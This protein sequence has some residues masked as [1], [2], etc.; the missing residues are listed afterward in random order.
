MEAKKKRRKRK[1][2]A[3]TGSP[4]PT[5]DA[6]EDLVVEEDE[7]VLS[8]DDIKRIKEIANYKFDPDAPITFA[9]TLCHRLQVR[10]IGL[11]L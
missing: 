8:E 3:P 10:S 7:N 1:K 9:G 2:Q 4:V 5:A 6:T 11:H